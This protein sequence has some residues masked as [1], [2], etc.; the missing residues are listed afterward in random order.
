MP[1]PYKTPGGIVTSSIALVLS[2]IALTG[3]YAFDPRAFGFTIALYALGA[4]YFFFYSKNQLVAK[5]AE[6]EFALLAAAELDLQQ[7]D[8]EEQK[9]AV[10]LA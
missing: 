7:D 1:R 5:T 10:Q 3:V 8:E 2:L 6:E 9:P 4:C